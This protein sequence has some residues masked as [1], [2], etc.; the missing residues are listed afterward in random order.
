MTAPRE[1]NQ[2]T[3]DPVGED[4]GLPRVSEKDTRRIVTFV[5]RPTYLERHWTTHL[6]S[7]G[8]PVEVRRAD[9]GLGCLCAGEYRMKEN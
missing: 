6:L 9:C 8:R 7:D 4:G 2:L 5:R 1:P 3:L